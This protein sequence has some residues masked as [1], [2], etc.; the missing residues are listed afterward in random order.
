MKSTFGTRGPTGWFCGAFDCGRD[1]SNVKRSGEEVDS[2][3]YVQCFDARGLL[4][5]KLEVDVIYSKI[6]SGVPETKQTLR[7][8]A[9]TAYLDLSSSSNRMHTSGS[10]EQ[11]CL[12]NQDA[13]PRLEIFGAF[14]DHPMC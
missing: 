14:K 5:A 8:P 10:R 9:V 4:N 13:I 11:D 1:I 3:I 12:S 6:Y 7:G 2:E